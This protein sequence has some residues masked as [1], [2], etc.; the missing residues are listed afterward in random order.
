[1][2]ADALAMMQ[3]S[4]TL[5]PVKDAVYSV[6]EISLSD[7]RDVADLFTLWDAVYPGV[8]QTKFD[9][10]YRNGPAGPARVWVIRA[11]DGAVAGAAAV[12]PRHVRIAG[13]PHLAGLAGDFLIHPG[14]RVLGPAMAL[15]RRICAEATTQWVEFL[16]GFPNLSAEPMFLRAGFTPLA[17]RMRWVMPIRTAANFVEFAGGATWGR[18]VAPLAD[19]ALGLGRWITSRTPGIIYRESSGVDDRFAQLGAR[20]RRESAVALERSSAYLRWRYVEAPIGPSTIVEAHS[21]QGELLGYTIGRIVDACV[22]VCELVAD[23]AGARRGLA[24]A[25]WRWGRRHGADRLEHFVG[26]DTVTAAQLAPAGFV[27]RPCRH[28]ILIYIPR[29]H[30][31]HALLADRA[32]WWLVQSDADT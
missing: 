32:N 30:Q 23:D 5:T 4:N 22:E 19:Q 17:D 14:H 7:P 16:Y 13:V 3:P 8:L 1:M 20:I 29:D 26:Q 25:L 9:W 28:R 21:T 27:Q 12:F 18:A 15:Q 24:A 10:L 2:R 11:A 6:S 31:H